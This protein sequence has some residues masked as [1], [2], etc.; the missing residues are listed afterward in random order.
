M[1]VASN[2]QKIVAIAIVLIMATTLVVGTFAQLASG[3][4]L[5]TTADTEQ[6]VVSTGNEFSC[7]L[8]NDGS[9]KCWGLNNTGQLGRDNTTA[10]GKTAAEMTALTAITLGAGRTA[11]ALSAGYNHACIVLDNGTVKCWG[12]NDRGQLGQGSTSNVGDG[13]GLL[14][15]ALPAIDL[16]AGVTARDVVAGNGFSCA[17]LND[18]KVKCWGA[19]EF[20]Q[21]GVNATDNRGDGANEMGAALPAIDFGP[22]KTA[23]A[24]AAADSSVCAVLNLGEVKCWGLNDK[25]QLGQGN[26]TNLG[27]GG[28]PSVANALVVDLGSEKTAKAVTA[29]A[30]HF[31][32][33]LSD[34]TVKC[35]GDN[36]Q[37]QLGVGDA[38]DRGD[39]ANEMGDFLTTVNL[40]VGLTAT[41]VT[42]GGNATCAVLSD[43]TTKC[44]GDNDAGQLGVGDTISKS[45][46]SEA[47]NFGA[48]K[49][50]V[51]VSVGTNSTCTVLDD[52]SVK[53]WGDNTH[54][55]LGLGNTTALIA[56]TA[57]VIAVDTT[58]PSV[59]VTAPT[60]GTPVRSATPTFS[61]KCESR[62]TVGV[63]VYTGA[64]A[65]GTAIQTLSGLCI[66]GTYSLT[67]TQGLDNN[68]YTFVVTQTDAAGN[69]GRTLPVTF[70]LAATLWSTPPIADVNTAIRGT[71]ITPIQPGSVYVTKDFGFT[72][73]G[74][75]S[76]RARIRMKDYVGVVRLTLTANYVRNGKTLTYRCTYA[77]FGRSAKL[78]KVRWRWTL[79]Q[80]TCVLPV[81][82]RNQLL[83]GSTTMRAKGNV[84]RYWA[85]TGLRTRP[86]GTN[87]GIRRIN[88]VLR[89]G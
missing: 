74:D 68:A 20:G 5:R 38:L 46:P 12:Q 44:W 63:S 57:T 9:V 16:G 26:T 48:G 1:R 34:N 87:I 84:T 13:T 65:T 78:A 58:A 10:V 29:G 88:V 11:I 43:T 54:G 40:G 51:S 71:F 76:L 22:N 15:S 2:R 61:G 41:V 27:D 79:S 25:G 21:L 89:N 42:A 6:I 31:C 64:S 77:P 4:P 66:G 39:G 19:N 62:I 17:L 50:A 81:A 24:L 75:R 45:S 35:W 56:P 80:R 52:V 83:N 28:T 33:I 69:A 59:T 85:E 73:F 23:I 14:M 7:A 70:T 8:L 49:T 55:Q 36:G 32:A 67:A 37:G 3:V 47:V 60:P 18:S 30:K 82:L 53:C 86:D 72:M